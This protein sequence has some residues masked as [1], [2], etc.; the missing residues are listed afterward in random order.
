MRPLTKKQQ[1]WMWFLIL[2][3]GGLAAAG[4]LAYLVRLLMG[5]A[6]V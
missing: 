4:L 3:W 6:K 5:I 2:W 1:Q